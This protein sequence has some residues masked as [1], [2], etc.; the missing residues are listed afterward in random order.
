MLY[1]HRNDAGPHK[2]LQI[3]MHRRSAF[4]VRSQQIGASQI[5]SNKSALSRSESIIPDSF[6]IPLRN[7]QT[8]GWMNPYASPPAQS[9]R[10]RPL[11]MD[12]I[13]IAFGSLT[14]LKKARDT[15][16]PTSGILSPFNS[17]RDSIHLPLPPL[18]CAVLITCHA[19]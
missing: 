9:R 16:T 6:K 12:R 14:S 5:A 1:F 3:G 17:C 13:S 11:E 7:W 18:P 4:K 10:F 8:A 19:W 15:S 2:A